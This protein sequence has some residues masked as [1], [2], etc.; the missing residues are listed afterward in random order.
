MELR[1]G[2]RARRGARAAIAVVLAALAG[3]LA[4]GCGGPRACPLPPRDP[5]A[6]VA[7]LLWRV[8]A[9]GGGPVLW[10][11]GTIHDAGADDVAAAAWAAL[12]GAPRLVSELGDTEP[13]GDDFREAVRLPRGKG[14]DQLLPLDDWW[15]LR[16]T[17]RGTIR[18]EDLAR[19][20]PWYA[21]TL[22]T[23][24]VTG[25]AVPGMDVLIAEH[26]RDRGLPVLALETWDEQ[27]ALLAGAV[28]VDDLA[29]A[30]RARKAM[31][32]Q[33]VNARAAYVAGELAVMEQ[34]FGVDRSGTLLAPRNRAWLPKLEA[35]LAGGGA[36]VAV[37]IGHLVGGDGLPALFA[38]A[39]YQVERA[40]AAAPTAPPPR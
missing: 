31:R 6:A 5:A 17:L 40:P 25:K 9:A 13:D 12:D 26:A 32:C 27:L 35:Y 3:V 16:D 10:L 24:Q 15:D 14:L 33:L 20:R 4:V 1:R 29:Q 18:E 37:G 23:R 39:G 8:Q 36:F 2:R 30:I 21:M 28:T 34:V 11:Y 7:P 38:A 19:V 22:L